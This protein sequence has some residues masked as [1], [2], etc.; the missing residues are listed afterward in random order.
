M[1]EVEAAVREQCQASKRSADQAAIVASAIKLGRL[2]DDPDLEAQAAGNIAKL[3]KLHESLG[4]PRR[5][6]NN[7]LAV[8]SAMAGA[9]RK[10]L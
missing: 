5:K 9:G 10:A 7:H 4:K 3:A 8:V 6:M 1:G 2:I